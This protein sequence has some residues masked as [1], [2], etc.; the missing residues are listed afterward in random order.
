MFFSALIQLV[1][2]LYISLKSIYALLESESA[3]RMVVRS[4]G[5]LDREMLVWQIGRL[6]VILEKLLQKAAREVIIICFLLHTT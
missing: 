2:P 5:S 1:I 6:E 4:S 3:S